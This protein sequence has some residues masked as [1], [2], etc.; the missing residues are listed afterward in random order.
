[1]IAL[2]LALVVCL[3]GLPWC[4]LLAYGGCL[5]FDCALAMATLLLG[6]A[7]ILASAFHGSFPIR[8]IMASG[9]CTWPLRWQHATKAALALAACLSHG[10]L[11]HGCYLDLGYV[12]FP[13]LLPYRS[14]HS[15]QS[16]HVSNVPTGAAL[17]L[18]LATCPL[19][20]YYF[21]K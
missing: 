6:D 17:A 5:S 7:F 14:S 19:E 15:L 1:M 2:P 20:G 18:A 10:S 12:S 3:W 4:L 13:L 8:A 11:T 9:A 16:T 21:H